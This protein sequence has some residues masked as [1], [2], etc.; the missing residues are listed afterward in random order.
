MTLADKIAAAARGE[1]V[2]FTDEDVKQ[3][4]GGLTKFQVDDDV[5]TIQFV[6]QE[7]VQSK[8]GSSEL[9]FSTH[10]FQSLAG[11]NRTGEA[12]SIN[13]TRR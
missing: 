12:I 10:G 4:Q 8:R 6:R 7:G 11:F 5:V 9:L 13:Y 2:E 3:A 1:K